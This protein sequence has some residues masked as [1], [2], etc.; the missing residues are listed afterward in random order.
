MPD[1]DMKEIESLLSQLN[2]W[3]RTYG[4]TYPPNAGMATTGEAPARIAELKAQLKARGAVFH[5]ASGA[6]VIDKILGPGE[7]HQGPDEF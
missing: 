2:H 7:G 5:W 4:N 1:V 3:E 6:Y